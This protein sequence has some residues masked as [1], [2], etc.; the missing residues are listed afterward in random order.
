MPPVNETARTAKEIAK[1]IKHT[2]SHS[3][4]MK[5]RTLLKRFGYRNMTKTVAA[6][7]T[8]SLEDANV[9]LEINLKD[10]AP[11]DFI[12]LSLKPTEVPDKLLEI[13]SKKLDTEK[14]VEIRF[15]VPLLELLG[16]DEED[17]DDGPTVEMSMGSKK[18]KK[19]AD[20]I[21]YNGSGERN[22]NKALLVVEAKNPNSSASVLKNAINQAKS[23]AM[24]TGTPYYMVTNGNIIRIFRYKTGAQDE[25]MLQIYRKELVSMFDDLYELIGKEAIINLKEG[26]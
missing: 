12:T 20:F 10:C 14:S 26:L 22:V 2:T 7:I 5:R 9:V 24:W 8:E 16:Y 4:W 13:I 17:R 21:L 25:E 18:L 3:K 15:V 19:E 23:Y 1:E 6:N 11:N